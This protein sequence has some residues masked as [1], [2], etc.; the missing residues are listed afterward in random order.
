MTTLWQLYAHLRKSLPLFAACS[1]MSTPN[2]PHRP[3]TETPTSIPLGKSTVKM[4]SSRVFLDSRVKALQQRL[5]PTFS[6]ASKQSSGA[7]SSASAE[8]S[9]AQNMTFVSET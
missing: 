3:V 7:F 1:T 4:W 2:W 9:P 6:A 8:A 5:P